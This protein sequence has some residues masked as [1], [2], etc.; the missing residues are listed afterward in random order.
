[1]NLNLQDKV[2]IVTGG[3]SGIGRSIALSLASEKAIVC[4]IDHNENALPGISKE[5]AEAGGQVLCVPTELTSRDACMYA[6]NQILIKYEKIDGLVNNAGLNDGVGL[7]NGDIKKFVESID[8]NV[9]HYYTMAELCL[10]HI[11]KTK[12]VIVNICSKTGET[13]QGGTSGYAAA[14]GARLALTDNLAT[15]FSS[16]G[17]RVNAV[18]VAECWTPQYKWWISQQENPEEKLKEITSKIPLEN[19]MTT[20]EEIAD[21]VLF[22]LSPKSS[23]INGQW[24]HVDGGY[25]HLD[26]AVAL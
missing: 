13:G 17:T 25:V 9:G 5:I 24:M 8:K 3:A 26:R 4:I 19:R 10:P 7:E 15:M 18:V 2:V 1:M 21:T 23:G 12:G 14:N 22:L 20:C 6:V 16:T 11:K